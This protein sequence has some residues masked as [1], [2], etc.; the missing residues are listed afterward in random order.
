M[1]VREGKGLCINGCGKIGGGKS[2]GM[3]NGENVETYRKTSFSSFFK[4][5][6]LDSTIVDPTTNKLRI[7]SGILLLE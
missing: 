5:L 1:S 6:P 7:Q 4:F 3:T 2:E